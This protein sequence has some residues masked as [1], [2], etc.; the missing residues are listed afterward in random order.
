[1]SFLTRNFS[2]VSRFLSGWRNLQQ[3]PRPTFPYEFMSLL[4][5]AAHNTTKTNIEEKKTLFCR[6]CSH[7]EDTKAS[8][9]RRIKE[10]LPRF[11]TQKFHWGIRSTSARLRRNK[12]KSRWERKNWSV[13]RENISMFTINPQLELLW[14]RLFT[15][16]PRHW[17]E[18]TSAVALE[19]DKKSLTSHEKCATLG[20]RH[21]S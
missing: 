21:K 1:V 14:R 4:H 15:Y 7:P 11:L 16:P 6:V 17:I 10:T 20:M 18:A 2:T 8:I 9:H 5:P 3:P 13:M 12:G 19:K